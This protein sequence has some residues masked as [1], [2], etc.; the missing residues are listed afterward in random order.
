V[1]SD[2][3]PRP[4]LWGSGTQPRA[5]AERAN[6]RPCRSAHLANTSRSA[7]CHHDKLLRFSRCGQSGTAARFQ[8]LIEQLTAKSRG[9]F[10]M[11]HTPRNSRCAARETGAN[12]R[13]THGPTSKD[14]KRSFCASGRRPPGVAKTSA[15]ESPKTPL[16]I[17]N[18]GKPW[19]TRFL[20]QSARGLLVWSSDTPPRLAAP[21]HGAE[22]SIPQ[23]PSPLW[24]GR[25]RS[26]GTA[27]CALIFSSNS[28]AFSGLPQVW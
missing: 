8:R 25:H 15:G 20:T 1:A 23:F 27:G 13:V 18:T 28:A 12:I 3:S 22:E 2:G 11:P 17:Q 9:V 14:R 26:F 4:R 10:L 24:S 6:A 21:P 19:K 5:P 16:V 7:G